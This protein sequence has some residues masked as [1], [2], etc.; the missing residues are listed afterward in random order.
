MQHRILDT[1]IHV[2]N[3]DKAS[4]SWLDGNTTILNR[5]YDIGELEEE[6]L[7]SGVTGGILVQAANNFEDTDWMIEVANGHDWI[8]GVVGWLPLMHPNETADAL[9]KCKSNRW[10]KGVRHLIHDE[11]D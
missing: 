10:F 7:R 3:F 1:H 5:N 6:R 9:K 11:Q 8:K 4:Y 2:W